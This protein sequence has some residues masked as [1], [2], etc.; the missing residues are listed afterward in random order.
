[1]SYPTLN[2]KWV[3]TTSRQSVLEFKTAG[4]TA[5]IIIWNR[6]GVLRYFPKSVITNLKNTL[7]QI[8]DKPF[9][10]TIVSPTA[11]QLVWKQGFT[12]TREMHVGLKQIVAG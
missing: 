2:I 9:D 4:L 3:E 8:K 10:Q 6:A 5:D 11:S 12:L 7:K 1:M